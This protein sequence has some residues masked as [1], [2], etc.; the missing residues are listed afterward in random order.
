M[1]TA[2]QAALKL[3]AWLSI[4]GQD[5]QSRK[6]LQEARHIGGSTGTNDTNL[7]ASLA[8]DLLGDNLKQAG[9]IV[10][11]QAAYRIAIDLGRLSGE[12]KGLEIAAHACLK[13]GMLSDGTSSFSDAQPAYQETLTIS[14]QAA[15]ANAMQYGAVAALLL[16]TGLA[17]RGQGENAK[18]LFEEAV[19]LGDS[20]QT[21]TGKEVAD[22]ARSYL[23][24][25]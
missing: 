12:S 14:R 10:E 22:Q 1:R 18:G 11:A 13:T 21:K 2:A 3:A 5:K 4:I 24:H 16:G 23:Q 25:Q 17:E 8:S 20:S 9:R 19:R 7:Q 6:L 15:T